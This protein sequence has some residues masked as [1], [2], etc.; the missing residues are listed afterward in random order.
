MNTYKRFTTEDIIAGDTQFVSEPM[1][2]NGD[3]ILTNAEMFPDTSAPVKARD[4]Y[5]I[6]VYNL[7]PTNAAA[8]VQ[9]SIAYGHKDG[10]GTAGEEDVL[11]GATTKPSQVVYKQFASLL[12]DSNESLFNI[13]NADQ[14]DLYFISIARARFKQKLDPGN[15]FLQVGGAWLTDGSGA[16]Q[17]PSINSAGTSYPVY[18]ISPSPT[19]PAAT[20]ATGTEIGRVYPDMGVIVLVP[21]L[22][23]VPAPGT[24]GA[25]TPVTSAGVGSFYCNAATLE[26]AIT[27]FRARTEEKI[28]SNYYFVRVTNQQ[29]NYSSNPTFVTGSN[30]EFRWS[31][32]RT[33]PQTYIT[34][35]GLYDD[36]NQLLAVAKLSKPI[37][38]NFNREALIKV[39]IDY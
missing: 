15:W 31:V 19:D 39:K 24:V 1:W 11:G 6:N 36:A 5:F 25:Q 12:L 29:F 27:E 33:H 28:T 30:G 4:E 23:G 34:T 8:E 37:L 7:T 21:G 17:D 26:G 3:G 13:N 22:S 35:V 10:N 2:S 18:V 20:I 14:D 16:G 38:K 32:M 9:Y